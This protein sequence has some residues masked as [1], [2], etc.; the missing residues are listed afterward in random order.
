MNIIDG[1]IEIMTK[2][3]AIPNA[4][5]NEATKL[6]S[7]IIKQ[8]DFNVLVNLPE[9]MFK[10]IEDGSAN[11]EF[12]VCAIN[13]KIKSISGSEI[14]IYEPAVQVFESKKKPKPEEQKTQQNKPQHQNKQPQHK[15]PNQNHNHH[16]NH[17][18]NPNKIE[19]L[20]RQEK[21]QSKQLE[22]KNIQ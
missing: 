16:Q 20:E 18:I 21:K 13:G 22:I 6:K 5:Y 12:W 15:H 4:E 1:K 8:G 11:F 9:K 14:E 17:P 3:S 19:K 10:R 7:F 2:I